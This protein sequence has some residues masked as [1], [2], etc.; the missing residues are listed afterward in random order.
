MQTD[1]FAARPPVPGTDDADSCGSLQEHRR[2]EVTNSVITDEILTYDEAAQLL[3]IS[4]RTLER[5]TREGL[6]PYIRL[7]HR[8]TCAPAR[9]PI[10]TAPCTDAAAIPARTRRLLSPSLRDAAFVAARQASALEQALDAPFHDGDQSSRV[11]R[12]VR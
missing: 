2:T 6:V 7:P 1:D 5:W 9:G 8:R 3:K 12:G 10:A 4:A 11:R